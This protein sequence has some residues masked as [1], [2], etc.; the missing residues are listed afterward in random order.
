MSLAKSIRKFLM[1]GQ[2]K[3]S[4]PER[5]EHLR[6][7]F[8]SRYHSFKLLL[9]ANRRALEIIT[10][11]ETALAGEKPFGMGYVRAQCTRLAT[12][13]FQMI[14]HLNE[15][16]D[17]KYNTNLKKR[18]RSI[19]ENIHYHLASPARSLSGPLVVQLADVNRSSVHQTGSKMSTLGEIKNRLGLA[20]PGGFVVTA[21]AYEVFMTHQDLRTGID[22]LIVSTER[23]TLEQLHDLS[24]AI[25]DLITN[26]SL[27]W[28][29]EG[30]I[31]EQYHLLE[32]RLGIGLPVVLRSSALNE[33]EAGRTF[34]GQ[35]RTFF[36]VTGSDLIRTYKKV[37]A[38]KYR[39]QAIMYRL[40]HG[41]RDD[42]VAMCVG[43]MPVVQGRSG[44]IAYSRNPLDKDDDTV[45]IHSVWG[46]PKPIVD[47]V[48]ASDRFVVSR[49]DPLR[50]LQK[51]IATKRQRFAYDPA[52]RECRT[53]PIPELSQESSISDGLVI[54]I[55]R[56]AL[57]LEELFEVPQ[58][59][60]WAVQQD[61]SIALLQS[62]PLQQLDSR[63]G[64]PPSANLNVDEESVALKGGT[65]ASP[66][67]ASGP[68]FMV[69]KLSDAVRCPEGSILVAAQSLPYWATL[70]DRA[71]AVITEQ[72]GVVGHLANVAREF[73]VPALFGVEGVMTRFEPGEV[74][75]VN[76]DTHTI[77]RGIIEAIVTNR[78]DIPRNTIQG[79]R[80]YRSL[81]GAAKHIIPLHLLDPTSSRFRARNCL[82]FHDITRFC[83]EKAVVGMF[84]FGVEHSFPERSS[85]QLHCDVPM[86]FWIIDLDDGFSET[87]VD[88]EYVRLEQITSIPML[89][90]WRGMMAITWA[91]PPP[92]DARGF[93]SVLRESTNDPALLPSMPSAYAV[94]NYFMI[95]RN[96]CSLQSRFGYHFSMVEALV[97]ERVMENYITFQFKGGAA[98]LGRRI[99]RAR[100]IAEVL[101][102]NEFSCS[103]AEDSVRARVEGYDQRYMEMKLQI[104]GYLTIH[105]RQL[106]MVATSEHSM[107]Q[108]RN[109]IRQDLA[110]VSSLRQ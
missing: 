29:L 44:G 63:R 73:K 46:L 98:N 40:N 78:S 49:G 6:A 88:T 71:A 102:E 21:A 86:Q 11:L 56:I 89:A 69:R 95:S 99:R 10:D 64:E 109:K 79:G 31:T 26:A 48:T 34:A 66:G 27:P 23:E 76:A 9:I 12:S 85:K 107:R 72:G 30:A 25:E 2:T 90:L 103:L 28:E 7:D 94:R 45:L 83:H 53:E 67:A 96:Y 13:V 16:T 81:N 62:R 15:I 77:Y 32:Q 82:T 33:D 47:G 8:K 37:V 74:V 3:R 42:D 52:A 75:T 18:F 20:V 87:M 38:S 50:L 5:V 91:G 4:S 57:S 36:N 1:L 80:V 58:D 24:K 19:Q 55:A 54:E 59:V 100:L 43:V 51:E 68:V 92:M 65:T 35:Y 110:Q 22:E 14:N 104:L 93:L 41:I 108:Y 39:F 17:G 84:Q 97:G 105:T 61:G 60:E 101:E 70:M 106:D